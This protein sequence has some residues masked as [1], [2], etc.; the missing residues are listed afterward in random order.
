MATSRTESPV[1]VNR[2]LAS[3]RRQVCR[4]CTGET[5]YSS[6][7]TR[8][9]CRAVQPRD[10]ASSSRLSM[11]PQCS[12]KPFAARTASLREA[13]TGAQS[14]AVSGAALRVWSRVAGTI[15]AQPVPVC[16]TALHIWSRVAGTIGAQPGASSG[17]HSRQG[18]KPALSASAAV[19]KKVQFSGL[20]RR[21]RHTGRQ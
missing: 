19:L 8:R 12:S 18:R 2:L 21:A 9:R 14:G 5:R 13:S 20:G 16:G 6:R 11:L 3:S 1:S 7:N 17:R 4:Y 15:G 10:A